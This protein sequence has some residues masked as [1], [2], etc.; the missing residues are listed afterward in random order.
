MPT[1]I[2]GTISFSDI[3]TEFG[4][5]NPI[6]INEYYQN[7]TSTY[8]SGVAGIPNI[9]ATISLDMFY[10]KSKI[11][12]ERDFLYSTVGTYTFTVPAGVTN[13][14]VLCIGAGGG[15]SSTTND[16]GGGGGGGLVYV[17]NIVVSTNQTF[18]V[19]VGGGG[20][21]GVNGN[22]SSFSRL[23]FSIIAYGG[24]SGTTSASNSGGSFSSPNLSLSYSTTG[25]GI[26]GRGGNGNAAFGGN[27]CCGGGGGAAGYSGNGGSGGYAHDASWV[28]HPSSGTGGGGGVGMQETAMEV[29]VVELVFM[30]KVIMGGNQI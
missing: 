28:Y 22:A 25:G 24:R 27:Y 16:G 30:D 23:D 17:N 2:S 15:G 6:E 9:N 8:T 29:V 12:I 20:G 11:P 18:T 3:Q 19:I 14:C 10:N 4:G 21:T 7:S 13:I 1:P 5:V 26:G